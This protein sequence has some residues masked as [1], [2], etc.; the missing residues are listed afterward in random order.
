MNTKTS[1]EA[2]SHSATLV[3]QVRY[4]AA[5]HPYVDPHAQTSETLAQLKPKVLNHFGLEEGSVEGGTKQYAFSQDGVL[6]TDLS[7]NLGSLANGKHKIELN[8][9]EQFIQG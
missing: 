5:G 7:A 6:L 9:L 4:L 8:L 2:A 3:V 1:S